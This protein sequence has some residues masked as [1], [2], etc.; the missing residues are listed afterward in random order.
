MILPYYDR[1][2]PSRLILPNR[3]L[4]K[5]DFV[6]KF[7]LCNQQ[8]VEVDF[9]RNGLDDSEIESIV[10]FIIKKGSKLHVL[11]FSSNS[12]T[13]KGCKELTKLFYHDSEILTLDLS[14]ND[15]GTE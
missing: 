12:I 4:R 3:N 2:H 10:D 9:S 14:H 7:L 6:L 15:V 13:P 1:K 11:N 5:V 8:I